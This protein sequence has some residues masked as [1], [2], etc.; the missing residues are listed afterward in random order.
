MNWIN[1]ISKSLARLL[2]KDEL[3]SCVCINVV[4]HV[5]ADVEHHVRWVGLL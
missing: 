5:V 3:G 4:V 2:V 1:C